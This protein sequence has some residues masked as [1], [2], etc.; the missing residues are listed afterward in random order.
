[1]HDKS[2]EVN[3]IEIPHF[4]RVRQLFDR[5]CVADV[6]A[7]SH[8]A[9][10]Q[11][12][13]GSRVQPGQSVA[14][15]VGS[16][17]ISN[18]AQITK[19]V[20]EAILAMGAIP[21]IVP[22][23]GSHGGAT[24]QGQRQVVHELGITQESMGCEIRSSM[25]TVEIG[26]S[27]EGFPIYFDRHAFEADHVV[28]VNRIKP[29]TR[30][31][32]PVESGLMK[33]MLIGLGKHAG[34][35]VYHRVIQ[36]YSFDQIVRSVAREVIG[37][38]RIAAGIAILENAYEET[39]RIVGIAASEIESI[40]P[41]LLNEVRRILPK[42]PFDHAELLIVDEIGKNI[43]GAGMDTNV[44]G[45]KLNDRAAING[46]VPRIHH[47]YVRSLSKQ[48]QGNASGIGIAEMCHDRVL[49]Q[50]DMV[51][52]RINSITASHISA[53]A[54]PVSFSNDRQAIETAVRMG[55][56]GDARNY[57][58]MWISNTLRLDEVACSEIYYRAA[59][60]NKSL[61]ILT[62]PEPLVWTGTGDLQQCR[63]L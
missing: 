23:M 44:I 53:A 46:E 32:G 5:H 45:R 40:E 63:P 33:M 51:K 49:G 58:A 47:I 61:E 19:S 34:A 4:F 20:V 50:I 36:N 2:A 22:A 27:N 60:E 31:S 14:V 43:S 38:C 25:D 56:W 7:S 8:L 54:M 30:F 12:G 15:T 18:I 37:R 1:M 17:G 11:S 52:T 57:P 28:V 3:I 35:L 6:R 24:A 55:G 42:L 39:A 29:H 41:Q 59:Q 26:K 62:S 21:F 16:R 10:K 13:L 9:I 48:T